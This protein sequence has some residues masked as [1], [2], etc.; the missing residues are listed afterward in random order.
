[1]GNEKASALSIIMGFRLKSNG[2]PW[3]FKD[4]VLTKLEHP[5]TWYVRFFS[6]PLV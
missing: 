1:L 4:L 5:Y 3:C 6:N 2:V